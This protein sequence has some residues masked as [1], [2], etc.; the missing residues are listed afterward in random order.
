M[1]ELAPPEKM[2]GEADV[3][4]GR[5]PLVKTTAVA[6]LFADT[7]SPEAEGAYCSVLV[8]VSR[9]VY[10]D[11]GAVVD[12]ATD[13]ADETSDVAYAKCVSDDLRIVVAAATTSVV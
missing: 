11:A 9:E 3:E 5:V 10:E 6:E 4:V 7:A 2:A 8:R 1:A 12:T 13:D